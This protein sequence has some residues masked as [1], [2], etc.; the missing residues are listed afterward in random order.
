[1]ASTKSQIL[2]FADWFE[3]GYKAGGPIRSVANLVDRLDDHHFHVITRNTDHA[4]DTPY[5]NIE[6]G[7]WQKRSEH[8]TVLYLSPEQQNFNFLNR[9]LNWQ[10]Y[11]AVY[12]NS[13]FSIP[14]TILPLRWLKKANYSGMVVLAPRGMLKKGALSVKKRKKSVF[15][16]LSRLS[17]LFKSVRWHATNEKEAEEIRQHFGKNT[18]IRIAPNLLRLP[19]KK[20]GLSTKEAGNLR[21]ISISRVS[22]E[23]GILES[24]R[25]L[26]DFPGDAQLNLDI[27]GTLQNPDYLK[28][29]EAE[30]AKKPQWNIRFR[31]SLPYPEV[32]QKLAE[33][34]FLYS[35]THG[36][37]FGHSIAE[38]FLAGRP[39]I[40]SDQTPWQKL[41][42][43][44]VGWDLPLDNLRFNEVIQECIEMKHSDYAKM[45]SAAFQKGVTIAQNE[46]DLQK[47]RQLFR[48]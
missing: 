36:E 2:V 25:F 7:I 45:S 29:C 30:A 15:L 37:N 1:M 5:P 33:A 24:I 42:A 13:L 28:L 47:N 38:A 22:P 11:D 34:H 43:E 23:K 35:T 41:K 17:G 19:E 44:N 31:G 10:D 12:L 8:V 6:A 46:E 20:P 39:V 14:Y 40:I 32:P 26:P 3:P 9:L 4:D 48:Y 18:D 21:L 27:Y 16:F